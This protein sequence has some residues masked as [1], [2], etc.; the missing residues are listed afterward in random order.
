MATCGD[1]YHNRVT[2]E[3]VLVLRGDEG[4]AGRPARFTRP[5]R[6]IRR[7][8]MAVLAPLARALV[9]QAVY[10]QYLVSHD[11]MTPDPAVMAAAGLA[12]PEGHDGGSGSA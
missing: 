10:S 2:G 4:G 7:A 8:V 12:T 6:P 3:R 5:P 9:Y 1:M 11:R